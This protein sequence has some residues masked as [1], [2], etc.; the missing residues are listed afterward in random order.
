MHRSLSD[1]ISLLEREGELVRIAAP[2]SPM[3]RAFAAAAPVAAPADHD[4]P[5][6]S[7]A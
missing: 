4:L 6:V 5:S 7:A 3:E 2:V 1:Y